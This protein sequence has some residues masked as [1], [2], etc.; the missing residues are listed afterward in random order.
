M[1]STEELAYM[2]AMSELRTLMKV[3]VARWLQRRQVQEF[4]HLWD[5]V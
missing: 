3:W 2:Q 5:G 1:S 4:C